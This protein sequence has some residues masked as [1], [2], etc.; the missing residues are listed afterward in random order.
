[1]M[2]GRGIPASPNYNGGNIPTIGAYLD[3]PPAKDIA[4]GT[5]TKWMVK[6]KE[7]AMTT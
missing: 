7:Y 3:L 1:M 5:V 6:L 2:K 4:H